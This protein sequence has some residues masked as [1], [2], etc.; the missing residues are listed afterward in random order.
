M[1]T[2]LTKIVPNKTKRLKYLS[3]NKS[4][5]DLPMSGSLALFVSSSNGVGS[6]P[7]SL[8]FAP[9]D[10]AGVPD[11]ENTV[12]LELPCKPYCNPGNIQVITV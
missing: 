2:N 7:I 5:Q 11:L 3:L 9:V 4:I 12:S 10:D 8:V 1:K 6:N